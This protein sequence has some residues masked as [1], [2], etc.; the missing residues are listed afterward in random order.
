MIAAVVI[1][2][3]AS[4]LHNDRDYD[5]RARHSKSKIERVRTA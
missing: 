2:E 3:R 4:L 1:R 5:V